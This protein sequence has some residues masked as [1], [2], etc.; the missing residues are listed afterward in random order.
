MCDPNDVPPEL[1]TWSSSNSSVASVTPIGVMTG[2]AI[3]SARIRATIDGVSE[4][5]DVRVDLPAAGQTAYEIVYVGGRFDTTYRNGGKAIICSDNWVYLR[6]DDGKSGFMS[7]STFDLQAFAVQEYPLRG[8]GPD[9][10]PGSAEVYTIFNGYSSSIS[11]FLRVLRVGATEIGGMFDFS[12]PTVDQDPNFV[13]RIRGSFLATP[14][15]P[16]FICH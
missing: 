7:L 8:S 14:D 6:T 13:V 5:L 3:G 10:L 9:T 16:S 12:A 11:G 4:G 2:E 1:V 15:D